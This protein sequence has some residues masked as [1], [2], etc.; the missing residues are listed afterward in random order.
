MEKKDSDSSMAKK[1]KMLWNL[2]YPSARIST[3]KQG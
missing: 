1:K 3:F 2:Q